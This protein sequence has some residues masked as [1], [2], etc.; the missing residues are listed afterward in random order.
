MA[1]RG[2]GREGERMEGARDTTL[3]TTIGVPT[4]RRRRREEEEGGGGRR[5]G[6]GRGGER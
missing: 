1:G 6:G 5:G 4:L 2:S 3:A